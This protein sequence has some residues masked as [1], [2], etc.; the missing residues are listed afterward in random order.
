MDYQVQVRTL[1]WEMRAGRAVAAVP[2]PELNLYP[3]LPELLEFFA[4]RVVAFPE[5][6]L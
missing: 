4:L 1:S 3:S 5:R 2:K 6:A